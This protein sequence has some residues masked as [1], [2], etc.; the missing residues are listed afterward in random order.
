MYKIDISVF[1][2]SELIYLQVGN[3][4][5]DPVAALEKRQE[6]ILA[7]LGELRQTLNKL[8]SQYGEADKTPRDVQKTG[9]PCQS[10]TAK[11]TS[12]L[13]SLCT[14]VSLE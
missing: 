12:P 3:P 14:G 1:L 4:S 7:R 5:L 2:L 10:A 11:L 8:T 6:S 9:L 13:V